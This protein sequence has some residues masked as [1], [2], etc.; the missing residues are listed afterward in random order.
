L[1]FRIH[2]LPSER[3]NFACVRVLKSTRAGSYAT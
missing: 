2:L 1:R 3:R